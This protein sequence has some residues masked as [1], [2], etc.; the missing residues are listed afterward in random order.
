[1]RKNNKNRKSDKE[2]DTNQMT[3]RQVKAEKGERFA[4]GDLGTAICFMPSVVVTL[5]LLLTEKRGGIQSKKQVA[6]TEADMKL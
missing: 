2:R 4:I 3:G 6:V 1:M 5:C